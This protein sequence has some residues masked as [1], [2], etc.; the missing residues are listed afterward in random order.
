MPDIPTIVSALSSIKTAVDIAKLI[1]ES[2]TS[3][4]QAEVKL[5]LAELISALADAKIEIA[6]VQE[7]LL[8]KDQLIAEL[9]ESQDIREKLRWEMPY[10]WLESDGVSA[11][12][13]KPAKMA[14]GKTGH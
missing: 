14:G 5:K 9:K 10:Y 7:T 4:E 12:V 13:K 6:N 11:P 2:S 8:K 1:K 3:L